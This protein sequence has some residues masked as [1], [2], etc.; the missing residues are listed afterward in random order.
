MRIPC[1]LCGTRDSREFSVTGGAEQMVRPSPEAGI[2]DWADW[3]HNRDNPAGPSRELWYHSPC[4]SWL[5]VDR[6]TVT[7]AVMGATLAREVAT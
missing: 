5:V 7:H 6:D 3:L 2:E 4:G 1:P